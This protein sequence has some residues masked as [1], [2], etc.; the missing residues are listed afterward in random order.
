MASCK[1]NSSAWVQLAAAGYCARHG[2]Q[3]W[4]SYC[5]GWPCCSRVIGLTVAW[6]SWQGRW[7]SCRL[8]P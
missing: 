1:A 4:R 2:V 8:Q 7:T 6:M 5:F 3:R